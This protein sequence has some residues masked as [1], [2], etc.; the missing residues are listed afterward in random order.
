VT[1]FADDRIG[2]AQAAALAIY[3]PVR[4]LPYYHE[5]QRII[6]AEVPEYTFNWLPEID[7]ANEDLRGLRPVP[8]GSDFWNVAQWS[9]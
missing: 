8:V 5:I 4:R 1:F 6:L 3:D 9:L 7:A 2:R